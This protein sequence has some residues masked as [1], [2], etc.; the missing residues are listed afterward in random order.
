MAQIV[1]VEGFDHRHTEILDTAAGVVSYVAGRWGGYALTAGYGTKLI[2]F[3]GGLSLE[4]E[5]NMGCAFYDNASGGASNDRIRIMN[6]GGAVFATFGATGCACGNGT[7]LTGRPYSGGT[8]ST[9]G[10]WDYIEVR[11]VYSASGYYELR[12][13]GVTQYSYTGNTLISGLTAGFFGI[14][15]W[16]TNI[17]AFSTMDDLWVEVGPG[18]TFRGDRRV[19]TLVPNADTSTQWTKSSGTAGNWSHV[20]NP[21]T[22][23]TYVSSV[24]GSPATDTYEMTDLP[25]VT[26]TVEAVHVRSMVR[27]SDAGVANLTMKSN[28]NSGSPVIVTAGPSTWQSYSALYTTN[29]GAAWTPAAVNSST[30]SIVSS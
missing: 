6:N 12:R 1:L 26:S 18:S 28:S 23:T 16:G 3:P 17:N 14:G 15:M 24:A 5:I 22:L 13:N 8:G 30:V 9:G 21:A 7:T 11:L 10:S 29:D 27:K 2:R 25:A 20:N 4:T 19:V